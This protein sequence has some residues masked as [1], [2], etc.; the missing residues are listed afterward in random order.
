MKYIA[1]Y[2]TCRCKSTLQT[3]NTPIKA[4]FMTSITLLHVSA[5]GANLTDS[6]RTK[7]I[8]Q[9]NELVKVSQFTQRIRVLKQK[10]T[11]IYEHKI[12][13]SK[14]SNIKTVQQ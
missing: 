6:N 4:Q 9:Y 10:F 2:S 3:N 12:I 5:W 1:P 13:N 14:R 11:L 8:I 7:N